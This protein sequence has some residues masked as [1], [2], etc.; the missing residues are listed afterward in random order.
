MALR[1][2]GARVQTLSPYLSLNVSPAVLKQKAVSA[3]IKPGKNTIHGED[4][5]YALLALIID[6]H[7]GVG[8]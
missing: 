4:A 2:F 3:I 7:V 8:G 5:I 1:I 6:P